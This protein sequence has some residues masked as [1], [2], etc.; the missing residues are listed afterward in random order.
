MARTRGADS[1]RELAKL[2]KDLGK[3][4]KELQKELRPALRKGAQPALRKAKANA[5]W[6]SR[7]P[8]ATRIALRLSGNRAGVRIVTNVRRAPHARAFEN[9]GRDGSFRRPVFGNRSTWV[10]QKAQPY[11]WPAVRDTKDDVV[12]EIDQA[13]VTVAK[14]AG[15]R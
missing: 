9:G 4:P 6:S 14:R 2:V 15:F 11:L 7:I 12:K 8:R 10:S 5:S 3:L 13:V 1:G